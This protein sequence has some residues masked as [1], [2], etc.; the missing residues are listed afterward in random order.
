MSAIAATDITREPP[1]AGSDAGTPHFFG[2][3]YV[4]ALIFSRARGL[5]VG[6]NLNADRNCNLDCSYLADTR[7]ESLPTADLDL[8]LISAELETTLSGICNGTLQRQPPFADL[9]QELLRLRH[10]MLTGQADPTAS[11][12]FRNVVET[13]VHI[14]AVAA[15]PF[16]KIVLPT[17]ASNLDAPQVLEGVKLFTRQD[18]IWARL[19]VGNPPFAPLNNDR[20]SPEK[21]FAN[22]LQL[23]RQREVVIQSL[24]CQVDGKRPEPAEIE[25][26]AIRLKELKDAGAQIPLVQVYSVSTS[27]HQPKVN[28]LPLSALSEIAR[29]VR[30]V[31]GLQT[32]VF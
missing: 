21:L 22:I 13:V 32:E 18:E 7:S 10:V 24:F 15:V 19:D 12:Q 3:R 14:R 2:N 25:A 1:K 9:P 11:P 31:S 27:T 26:Y 17:D 28:H 29:T 5:A 20:V 16:F 8:D 23:A 30:R 6:V 4:Y